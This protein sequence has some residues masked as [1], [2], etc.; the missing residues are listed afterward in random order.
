MLFTTS[1]LLDSKRKYIVNMEWKK[2]GNGVNKMTNKNDKQLNKQQ[3]HCR[4]K[5]K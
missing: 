4:D 2:N 3:Q 1:Y 5:G